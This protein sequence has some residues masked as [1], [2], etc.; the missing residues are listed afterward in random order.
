VL[1][2]AL[3]IE[4]EPVK[5]LDRFHIGVKIAEL[6]TKPSLITVG[7][8]VRKQYF[9]GLSVTTARNRG[10]EFQAFHDKNKALKWLSE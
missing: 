5:I 4:L 2:D 7:C 1:L 6:S 3:D 8:I 9:D 10:A